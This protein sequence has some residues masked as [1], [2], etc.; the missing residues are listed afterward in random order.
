[1]LAEEPKREPLRNGGGPAAVIENEHRTPVIFFGRIAAV[2]LRTG[3]EGAVTRMIREPEDLP[4]QGMP[5][6]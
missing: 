5:S 4:E 6:W 1:M 3:W 2:L